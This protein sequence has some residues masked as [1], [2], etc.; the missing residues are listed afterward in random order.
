MKRLITITTVLALM[1]SLFALT[2]FAEGTVTV[3]NYKELARAVNEQKADRIL[4]SPKYKHGTKEVINLFVENR[5]ITI[6]AENGENAVLDGRVD[7]RGDG[8]SNTITFENVSIDAS[9]T[10]NIGLWVGFGPKVIIDSVRGGD[11]KTQG[12]PG[13]VVNNAELF[14]G[15]V[16]GGDSVNGIA[17]DGIL[18]FENSIV[19]VNEVTGGSC[20]NG[21]GGAGV[22][23]LGNSTVAVIK[24]V[25]GGDGAVSP[26]KA[27]LISPDCSVDILGAQ[28]DGEKLESKKA[29]NPEII[30]SYALLVNALRNGKKEIRLDRSYKSGATFDS[31]D[32][33]VYVEGDGKVAIFGAYDDKLQKIDSG[34]CILGGEWEISGLNIQ[35][36]YT[37]LTVLGDAHLVYTGD[38][39]G[40]G[41][42]LA[43]YLVSGTLDVNGTISGSGDHVVLY[44]ENGQMTMDGTVI[45]KNNNNYAV[46]VQ[47]GVFELNGNIKAKYPSY[48]EGN[49]KITV[50]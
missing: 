21:V 44:V 6:A 17:G 40:N 49:G 50:N 24:S 30:N 42:Y 4:I 11:S 48:T 37:G 29:P 45:Q 38:I 22:V 19:E 33:P 31:I 28:K 14:V 13:A 32:T 18:A 15:T 20:A 10:S 1:L 7:I 2:A 36:K 27:T 34:L 46:Y 3:K 12:G 35:T 39:G 25:T 9:K 8:S 26:G 43:I 47:D 41:L 16:K 23:T 5:N